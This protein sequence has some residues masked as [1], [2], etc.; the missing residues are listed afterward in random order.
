M[1]SDISWWYKRK[2]LIAKEITGIN[3][4]LK[5]KATNFFRP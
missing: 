4:C 5:G 2:Y 1:S 3:R